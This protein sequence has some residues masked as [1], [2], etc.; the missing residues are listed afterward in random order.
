MESEL[1][2]SRSNSLRVCDKG[3]E[4]HQHGDRIVH[5][6]LKYPLQDSRGGHSLGCGG[7]SLPGFEGDR[8]R[9]CSVRNLQTLDRPIHS[10]IIFGTDVTNQSVSN[11]R[12]RCPIKSE[13]FDRCPECT[14]EEAD[15][16]STILNVYAEAVKQITG[17]RLK[18]YTL[19]GS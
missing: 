18:L 4:R 15:V 11:F 16:Q 7:L 12:P 17:H 1:L 3:S 2:L 10:N 6:I 9:V 8:C 14:P 19:A 13:E 5:C